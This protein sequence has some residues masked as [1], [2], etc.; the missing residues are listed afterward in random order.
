[1]AGKRKWILSALGAAVIISF[2]FSLTVGAKE[3]EKGQEEQKMISD[4]ILPVA[5]GYRKDS[6]EVVY[7]LNGTSFL[8]NEEA[9]LTGKHTVVPDEILL[10]KIMREQG[11]KELEKDDSRL[12]IYIM[13]GKDL[14]IP[15]QL[16]ENVQSDRMD[17]A[18]LNLSTNLYDREVLILGEGVQPTEGMQISVVGFP[19]KTYQERIGEEVVWEE[20][21]GEI[22]QLAVSEE[23]PDGENQTVI[24]H[25]V[26]LSGVSSGSPIFNE[27]REVIGLN[28]FREDR[29]PYA[30]QIYHIRKALD[31]FE[32]PYQKAETA[33]VGLR[34]RTK[35]RE[36]IEE[37]S[38]TEENSGNRLIES[39]DFEE[40]EK[41]ERKAESISGAVILAVFGGAAGIIGAGVA[42]WGIF[43]TD[44]NKETEDR[45]R[46]LKNE[47]KQMPMAEKQVRQAPQMMKMA[48]GGYPSA[49]RKGEEARERMG[50]I[51]KEELWVRDGAG[52]TTLLSVRAGETTL[53]HSAELVYLLRKRTGERIL[54]NV[55]PFL[56]GKEVRR[57]SYCIRDNT[58]V[59]RCHAKIT[60]NGM[61]YYIE[62][63]ESTNG[64][65]V[66]KNLLHPY[67]KVVLEDNMTIRLAD[68]M[69]EFHMVK[70]QEGE[71][72]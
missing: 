35:E 32:V 22:I 50:G 68:E 33:S 43:R 21:G 10:N 24:E 62:D 64:T 61:H 12:G 71:R 30:V 15:A 36:E 16:H 54:I 67:Q 46:E 49:F 31:L 7:Y 45:V 28:V 29:S 18:V 58:S 14:F 70:M 53:L 40:E 3:A 8:I 51:Q 23:V 39:Q 9:V 57:V 5:V 69:F 44:S 4:A 26:S 6:G 11:L 60:K 17:F 47:K 42:V 65:Y 38:E 63:Q 52:E 1:M 41:E 27:R 59:S 48:E 2:C 66:G 13:A 25:N 20:K 37:K 34:E 56:I 72:I 55:Q 19:E